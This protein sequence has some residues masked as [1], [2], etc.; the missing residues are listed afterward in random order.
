MC[1]RGAQLF[2]L[3]MMIIPLELGVTGFYFEVA[4]NY[5]LGKNLNEVIE[6]VDFC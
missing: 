3:T 1:G 4:R 5:L 6:M 2:S